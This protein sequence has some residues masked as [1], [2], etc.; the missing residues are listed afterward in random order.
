MIQVGPKPIPLS[1]NLSLMGNVSRI[2]SMLRSIAAIDYTKPAKE[3]D[4]AFEQSLLEL[5]A[6]LVYPLRRMIRRS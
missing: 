1:S 4:N 2:L 6:Q 5:A 3:A